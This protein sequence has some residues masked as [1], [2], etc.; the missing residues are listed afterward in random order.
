MIRFMFQPATC[1]IPGAATCVLPLLVPGI[2][3]ALTD[4]EVTASLPVAHGLTCTLQN[5]YGS[6]LFLS[7]LTS[8]N[9]LHVNALIDVDA[10]PSYGFT[11]P[12]NLTVRA[13]DGYAGFDLAH[14]VVHVA[15][16]NDNRP[17]ISP[18][19]FYTAIYG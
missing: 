3:M 13:S 17:V 2:G 1:C 14:I 11:H 18:T 10:M 12:L 16:I 9:T 8:C 19:S 4:R 6:A 7:P 15:D 5:A